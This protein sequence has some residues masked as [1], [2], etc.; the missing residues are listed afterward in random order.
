MAHFEESTGA[1]LVSS[2]SARKALPTRDNMRAMTD[3][4]M[5]ADSA[6]GSGVPQ[7]HRARMAA[8]AR[9][10]S[11][12][13]AHSARGADDGWGAFF[14]GQQKDRRARA[15]YM[16]LS[17]A[18]ARHSAG[19]SPVKLRT[20]P[21]GTPLP[22]SQRPPAA[23][24]RADDITAPRTPAREADDTPLLATTKVFSSEFSARAGKVQVFSLFKQKKKV[25][26]AGT[27]P[28]G[29]CCCG[30]CSK[31]CCKCCCVIS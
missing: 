4:P 18:A 30:L 22:L 21:R 29:K 20:S 16:A 23:T 10:H 24:D 15:G 1:S 31:N 8:R 14:S 12:G 5:Y 19:G 3:R 25:E 28:V 11:P 13:R 26:I 27:K 2:A 9:S 17:G 6:Y 7:S